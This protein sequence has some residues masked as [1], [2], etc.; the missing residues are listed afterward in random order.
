MAK[1][2][3]DASKRALIGQLGHVSWTLLSDD[4][5]TKVTRQVLGTL[6]YDSCRLLFR[7]RYGEGLTGLGDDLAP[8]SLYALT[9]HQRRCGDG[10]RRDVQ[11]C[12]LSLARDA[13]EVGS[14]RCHSHTHTR[15]SLEHVITCYTWTCLSDNNG[16]SCLK[17]WKCPMEPKRCCRH[18]IPALVDCIEF[19][20]DRTPRT[21]QIYCTHSPSTSVEKPC[22][23]CLL[24]VIAEPT[25][26]CTPPSQQFSASQKRWLVGATPTHHASIFTR[27]SS[28]V[29]F[30]PPNPAAF[31]PDIDLHM[32]T[33][34]DVAGQISRD[35]SGDCYN[36]LVARDFNV[37]LLKQ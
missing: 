12:C 33:L 25:V 1:S 14:C 27:T 26:M 10:E 9:S 7:L 28:F 5:S 23:L 8:C 6:A 4:E 15:M 11:G 3:H 20:D 30:N 16:E 24:V 35:F 13:M 19:A 18:D 2:A 37:D 22:L 17:I 29:R 34:F 21:Q 31:S 32:D 36:V